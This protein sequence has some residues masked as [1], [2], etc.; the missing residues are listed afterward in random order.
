MVCTFWMITKTNLMCVKTRLPSLVK[1]AQFWKP[2]WNNKKTTWCLHG[3]HVDRRQDIRIRTF[4]FDAIQDIIPSTC[5]FYGAQFSFSEG[6]ILGEGAQGVWAPLRF[7]VPNIF[8]QSAFSEHIDVHVGP[9][10]G[11]STALILYL[12][13]DFWVLLFKLVISNSRTCTPTS[14]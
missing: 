4:S 10:L 3:N 6:R 1:R 7:W 8:C 14:C 9:D 11:L 2:I 5:I 12:S 13:T